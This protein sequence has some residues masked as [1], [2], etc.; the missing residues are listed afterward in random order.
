[1]TT[2]ACNRS[3]MAADS[4]TSCAGLVYDTAKIVRVGGSLIGVGG[5]GAVMGKFNRWIAMRPGPKRDALAESIM[6]SG[7][8][9]MVLALILNRDG[10]FVMDKSLALEEVIGDCH[11]I[12]TGAMAAMA[13]IKCGAS[14]ENAVKIA[15]DLDADSRPPVV[16]HK[17]RKR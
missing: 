8:D 6:A 11:A 4:L 7:E 1:M 15:C 12:G 10:I 9:E 14:V 16:S 3:E 2:I 13:A 5:A 17:L